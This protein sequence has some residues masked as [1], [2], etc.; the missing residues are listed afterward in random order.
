DVTLYGVLGK[1]DYKS[2]CEKYN[3]KVKQ[4]GTNVFSNFNSESPPNFK[5]FMCTRVLRKI[6]GKI[7]EF[8]D[9]YLSR[10]V[11]NTLKKENN[12][13]LLISIAI[14]YPIHWGVALFRTLNNK[15]RKIKTWVADCGDPYMG[16]TFSEKKA[17]YFKYVEKWFCKKVDYLTVP[18]DEAK[19]A[20]YPEFFKKIVTIP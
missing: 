18:I 20:Y 17:F 15:S 2:F 13:D 8:P 7:F 5:E 3:V 9:I 12:I 19:Q 6:F 1:Y 4:L 14:P 16:N 10:M 11:Y